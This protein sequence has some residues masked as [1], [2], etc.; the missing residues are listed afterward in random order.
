MGSGP[1]WPTTRCAG[2][3]VCLA[4]R[5]LCEVGSGVPA[6]YPETDHPADGRAGAA[7]ALGPGWADSAA[8]CLGLFSA[9]PSIITS[10]G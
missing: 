6:P 1:V 8:D 4:D 7:F 3:I 9:C 10:G 2:T 5:A